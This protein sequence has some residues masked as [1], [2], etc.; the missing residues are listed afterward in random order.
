MIAQ[1]TTTANTAHHVPLAQQQTPHIMPQQGLLAVMRNLQDF[2]KA[3]EVI[4]RQDASDML[5]K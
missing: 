4:T 5:F 3:A 1:H 2:A